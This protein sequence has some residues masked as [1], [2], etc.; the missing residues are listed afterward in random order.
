MD[1]A[2]YSPRRAAAPAPVAEP[3]TKR[4]GPS[5]LLTAGL[6]SLVTL[7]GLGSV[8][9]LSSQSAGNAT[10]G[11]TSESAPPVTPQKS[12]EEI[13]AEKLAAERNAIVD[14]TAEQELIDLRNADLASDSQAITA[15]AE[16]IWN[17]RSFFWPTEGTVSPGN[18]WGMRYHPILHYTK[19]HSGTD[20]GG[21]CGQPIYAAQGGTVIKAQ[22][23]GY[24]SGSGLNVTI[25][26]GDIEGIAFK[27]AYLHMSKVL[28]SEGDVVKRG[29]LIG[30][31]GDTGLATSCHL[32]FSMY[33]DGKNIDPMTYLEQP[34]EG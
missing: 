4:S 19:M 1:D 6:L 20:I 13:A 8:T 28:V 16:R 12:E 33:A 5:R 21:A 26:H 14:D 30:N 34:A 32:H 10:A 29:Q 24:H 17:A 3:K 7:V 23:E 2:E 11:V 15:E 9:Y 18:G 31:V 27:T 25:D 22:S